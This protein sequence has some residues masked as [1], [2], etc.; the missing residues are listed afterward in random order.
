MEMLLDKQ[1]IRL[2]VLWLLFVG[3]LCGP[4][5]SGSMWLVKSH[6]IP[7]LLSPASKVLRQQT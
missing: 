1:D 4:S 3:C 2:K 5:H 7:A 6:R